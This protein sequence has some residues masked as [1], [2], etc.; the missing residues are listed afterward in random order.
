MKIYQV[1]AFTDKPFSGN[2]AAVCILENEM[3]NSWMQKVAG[4][5]NL[6]ETAFV[7]KRNNHYQLRWFT[8]ILEVELCG[9]ATLAS[10]HILYESGEVG[11]TS[12]ILFNTK[13][14]DLKVSFKEPYYEMDFPLEPPKVCDAPD[15]LLSAIDATPLYI[16][17]NRMD[18]ILELGSESIV[19]YCTPDLAKLTGID[20]RGVI[21]TSLS[22]SGKY[23]F[24]SR[25]FAPRFGIDEDPVTGSAHCC[26]GP[27]WGNKLNKTELSAFQASPRGGYIN[28]VLKGKRILLS[29]QA[30]T[31]LSGEINC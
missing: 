19:R 5:M 9:H 27:Y 11:L 2:P 15:G 22:D 6:P 29:G 31:V 1:D 20:A 13:S 8:P 17:R 7:L 30:V 3:D 16:G 24:I 21:I 23:D 12:P 28:M 10:A 14:G 25:F 4:E 18:Y 26:L